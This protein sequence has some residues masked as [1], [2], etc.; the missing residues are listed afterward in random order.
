MRSQVQNRLKTAEQARDTAR[1]QLAELQESIAVE[2]AARVDNVCTFSLAR[3]D[4]S[5]REH[6]RMPVGQ[7]SRRPQ[8][9]AKR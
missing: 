5:L 6:S 1:A 7:H 4:E 2:R 3:R 8:A 9:Y